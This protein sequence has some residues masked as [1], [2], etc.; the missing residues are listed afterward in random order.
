MIWYHYTCSHGHAGITKT[1]RVL[2]TVDL[3]A[4]AGTVAT[5]SAEVRRTAEL[6]WLTDLA[7][8]IRDALG[9]T[10]EAIACDRTRYRWRVVDYKPVR[11]VAMR[12]DL[13][14]A[15]RDSLESAHGA[16]PMHWWVAYTPVP[17]VYDPIETVVGS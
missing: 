5:M 9:L 17:V 3:V 12:R 6:I 15:L 13:P 14:R 7:E 16:L 11:Y 1:G 2:S 4:Q 10:S 8:P